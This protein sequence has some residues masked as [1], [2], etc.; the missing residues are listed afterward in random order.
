LQICPQ[1]LQFLDSRASMFTC[2][3]HQRRAAYIEAV[4]NLL[5]FN[6]CLPCELMPIGSPP[7]PRPPVPKENVLRWMAQVFHCYPTN[8]VKV[9]MEAQ[10][11][12]PNNPSLVSPSHPVLIHHWIPGGR[13]VAPYISV[14]A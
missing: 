11:T 12:D 14:R 1:H 8:N 7:F 9:L 2:Q 3:N 6:S 5:P 4:I 13:G 10:S